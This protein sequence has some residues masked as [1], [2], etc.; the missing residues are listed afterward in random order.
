MSSSNGIADSPSPTERAE[1]ENVIH[2]EAVGNLQPEET[3]NEQN[4][5]RSPS[6]SSTS[7]ANSNVSPL[8]NTSP[9]SNNSN[10]T[11]SS[12]NTEEVEV[13][14]TM[15]MGRRPRGPPPPKKKKIAVVHDQFVVRESTESDVGRTSANAMCINCK[16]CGTVW[17]WLRFNATTAAKHITQDCAKV[18]EETKNAI[19]ASSQGAKRV[20]YLNSLSNTGSNKAIGWTAF[21]MAFRLNRI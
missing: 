18:D 17:Y 21:G 15:F 1:L 6:A 8:T 20:T 7:P 12:A 9:E 14:H 3:D 16:H 10:D 4:R 11:P 5:L 2:W 13:V 19:K